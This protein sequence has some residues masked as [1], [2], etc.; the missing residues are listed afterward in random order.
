MWIPFW[1][2]IHQI[3]GSISPTK[4]ARCGPGL[5]YSPESK[6]YGNADNP[7][8]LFIVK[9]FLWQLGATDDK[10]INYLHH[11]PSGRGAVI[12][13]PAFYNWYFSKM[14]TQRE[15]HFLIVILAWHF[16][17]FYQNI[18]SIWSRRMGNRGSS[19]SWSLQYNRA[20]GPPGFH[21]GKYL[22]VLQ[23]KNDLVVMRECFKT[24]FT[25]RECHLPPPCMCMFL[26]ASPSGLHAKIECNLSTVFQG[27]GSTDACKFR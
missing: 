7:N 18:P 9:F 15:P 3:K 14:V 24:D 20:R 11:R 10:A 22:L 23:Q 27:M 8:A 17:V 2:H 26:R 4:Q 16:R 25:S 21:S 1:S 19:W 13:I 12:C 5:V 6:L